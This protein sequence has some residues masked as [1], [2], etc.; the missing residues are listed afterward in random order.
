MTAPASGFAH[1]AIYTMFHPPPPTSPPP[2]SS[3]GGGGSGTSGGT[4]AGA[5]VGALAALAALALL[6]LLAFCLR[7]RRRQR[8][9]RSSNNQ[10]QPNLLPPPLEK[11]EEEARTG[12]LAAELQGEACRQEM[13]AKSV[14]MMRGKEYGGGKEMGA[15]VGELDGG[16]GLPPP[17]YAEPVELQGEGEIAELPG[18]V[19]AAELDGGGRR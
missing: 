16:G 17:R 7:K 11:G 19:G 15:A 2:S 13:E 5:V 6:A 1:P 3:G 12:V 9:R 10:Q 8:Q 4:I 18:W 14:A